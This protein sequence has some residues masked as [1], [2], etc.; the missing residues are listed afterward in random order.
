LLHGKA[1]FEDLTNDDDDDDDAKTVEENF[2][3]DLT[4]D[5]DD[6]KII[7]ANFVADLTHDDDDAKI[8]EANFVAD[9]THED[10]D[11][12]KKEFYKSL[13]MG[14]FET[15]SYD[16]F[17][18][19]EVFKSEKGLIDFD[20]NYKFTVIDVEKDGNCFWRAFA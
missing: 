10:D 5:D 7:E 20:E 1:V 17:K 13:L 3:A 6:A 16:E 9:L 4:H 2:V 14:V 19:S 12:S 11:Y 8:I 15:K 18:N